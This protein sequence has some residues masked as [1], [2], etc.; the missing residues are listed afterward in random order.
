MVGER[1][2]LPRLGLT[3]GKPWFHQEEGPG[4]GISCENAIE[5]DA[6]DLLDPSFTR[7]FDLVTPGLVF[8]WFIFKGLHPALKEVGIE[9]SATA[10]AALSRSFPWFE[11]KSRVNAPSYGRRFQVFTASF[12]RHAEA[13]STNILQLYNAG[14]TIDWIKSQPCVGQ[15]IFQLSISELD[16]L[17]K[18]FIGQIEIVACKSQVFYNLSVWGIAWMGQL[19]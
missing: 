4:P 10:P 7:L 1:A 8:L 12:N 13:D 18:E 2:G 15:L 5:R 3:P 11:L 17:A 19:P 14:L 9:Q 16:S 6:K